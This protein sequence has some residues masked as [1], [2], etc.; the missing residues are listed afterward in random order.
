[1]RSSRAGKG[2]RAARCSPRKASGRNRPE[3]SQ[4]RGEQGLPGP[5][6]AGRGPQEP[7]LTCEGGPVGGDA[8]DPRGQSGQEERGARA[9]WEEGSFGAGQLDF[10]AAPP[11]TS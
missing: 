10:T 6:E 5:T 11:L 3:Q 8:G 2:Q 7:G 9:A 1:M 4:P